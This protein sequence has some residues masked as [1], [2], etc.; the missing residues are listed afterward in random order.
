MVPSH[1]LGVCGG[2]C[3]AEVLAWPMSYVSALY[4]E[5]FTSVLFHCLIFSFLE[6]LVAGVFIAVYGCALVCCCVLNL[7]LACGL[8]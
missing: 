6:Y 1:A 3:R 7:M 8:R 5:S 2:E 4:L